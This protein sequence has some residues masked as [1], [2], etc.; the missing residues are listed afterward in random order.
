MTDAPADFEV[1]DLDADGCGDLYVL[2]DL[3]A[4]RALYRYDVRAGRL[5]ESPCLAPDDDRF[6]DAAGVCVTAD[7]LYIIDQTTGR[8]HAFSRHLLQTRWIKGGFDRPIAIAGHGERVYLLEAGPTSGSEDA[9]LWQV[10]DDGR[11]E[12][13]EAS[14]EAPLD[15]TV[16]DAGIVYVLDDRA[17]GAVIVSVNDTETAEYAVPEGVRPACLEATDESELLVGI[18]AAPS[19]GGTLFRYRF[20]TGELDRITS[21]ER[22]CS[23]LCAGGRGDPLVSGI[24]A[25]NPNEP[26]VYFLEAVTRHRASRGGAGL[27]DARVIR[28]FD[29]GEAG[30]EW[31]RVVLDFD[32][33]GAGTQIRVRYHTTDDPRP[34]LVPLEAIDGV[35][36]VFAD[37]LRERGVP[38]ISDL[39]ELDATALAD[40][41]DVSETRAAG[42]LEQAPELL[43]T[44]D[45]LEGIDGIGPVTA[46]RLREAN[47]QGVSEL[48]GLS[49]AAVA[50][51]VGASRDRAA[52]L[53]RRAEDHLV[54]WTLIEPENPRDALLPDATGRYLWVTVELVGTEYDSPRVSSFRAYFPRQSY[55]RYLPAIYREDEAS[56]DFLERFL[57]NFEST[58]TGIEE[59]ITAITR[60]FDPEGVPARDLAWLAEWL[61]VEI[62][63]TWPEA[64]RRELLG[65]AAELSRARGTR[66]GLL[67]LLDI[68][69]DHLDAPTL[70]WSAAKARER[71]TL[72]ALV[73]AG[74][75]TD[76]E[77]ATARERHERLAERTA[78]PGRFLVEDADLDCIDTAAARAAYDRL[79]DCPQCFLVL[80]RPFLDDEQVRTVARIVE[81]VTPAHAVG[82]TVGLRPWIQLGSHAYLGV[83]TTLPKREFLLESAGLGTDAV[84]SERDPAAQLGSKSRLGRDSLIS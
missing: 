67:E 40:L 20:E 47:V 54:E 76:E 2:A 49:P 32:I 22:P 65:R 41:A 8:L 35:G 33:V 27:Y 16:D 82:R 79:L 17:S 84:L 18:G 50:D 51:I 11:R 9:A 6:A 77:A 24:Y 45:E 4:T 13:V 15:V 38:G 70:D 23:L 39:A 26:A 66:R 37:R 3:R 83:N 14:V 62:D 44:W 73:D 55:L 81:S 25:V 12:R 61:G 63:E 60:Y 29:S 53:L 58:F 68:Y 46:R 30:T 5:D 21:H 43:E 19:G 1:V 42:W 71:E 72:D 36:T 56:A 7:S 48:V 10:H 52:R 69:L 57:A 31:H 59:E 34:T 78:P 80:V 28:Q 74:H 75:L 64:A